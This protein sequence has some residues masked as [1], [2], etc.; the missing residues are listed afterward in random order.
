MN[1]V[2]KRI[3]PAMS[4]L[5]CVVLATASCGTSASGG[6]NAG[7]STSAQSGTSAGKSSAVPGEK[8]KLKFYGKVVEDASTE[9]KLAMTQEHFKDKYDIDPIQVDWANMTTVIQTGIASGDPADA[10]FWWNNNMASWVK[11]NQALDLTS[12][13]EDGNGEW[14]NTFVQSALDLGKIDGKYYNIPYNQTSSTILANDT[15]A[16]KLGITIPDN[17]TWDQFMEVCKDIKTK[18]GAGIFPFTVHKDWSIWVVDN[19]E[20]SLAEAAGKLT[21]WSSGEVPTSDPIFAA[22]LKNTV[23]LY[24]NNYVYPGKGA[25]TSTLDQEKAAFAQGKVVMAAVVFSEVPGFQ[26]LAKKNGFE[27]KVVKWPSMGSKAT[28]P[29]CSN[30]FF[31]PTNAKNPDASID[32]LKYYTGA[33]TQAVDAK[34]GI[35]PV[36]VNVQISDSLLN[37]VMNNSGDVQVGADIT[38]LGPKVNDYFRNEFVQSVVLDTAKLEDALKKLQTLIDEAKQ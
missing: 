36:N 23:D 5:L 2:L 6:E 22:S 13:L 32:F 9:E 19:G 17:M 18:G 3:F 12:Y 27:L 31:V 1:S 20:S 38:Q 29:G 14:K 4:I 28:I 15:L 34:N 21:E 11:S 35:I 37:D 26:E 8:I 33:E 16:K 30:G 7:G 10:Y 25:L 24:K